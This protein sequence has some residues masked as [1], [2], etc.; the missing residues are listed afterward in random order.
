VNFRDA[1]SHGRDCTLTSTFPA[2][3]GR[4]STTHLRHRRELF[5]KHGVRLPG[6]LRCGDA[7]ES[8][9]H[10]CPRHRRS[11]ERA[12]VYTD[13]PKWLDA[14]GISLDYQV[15]LIHAAVFFPASGHRLNSY[16]V[17]GHAIADIKMNVQPAPVQPPP[18]RVN[19][20]P[21]SQYPLSHVQQPLQSHG[22]PV[23]HHAPQ[24]SIQHAVQPT[25]QHV[26]PPAQSAP[27][28]DP[29]ILSMGKRTSVAPSSNQL[30]AAPPQEA[31]ATPIKPA[32]VAGPAPAPKEASQFAAHVRGFNVRK[33]SAATLEGPFSSLD[34]AD[35]EEADSET[36][37]AK[38]NVRRASITKTR[39][40]KPMD[41]PS[42]QKLDDGGKKT[43]R[44][45][46]SRKKE[47][48][49]Q[50]RK[51]GGDLHLSPDVVRKGYVPSTFYIVLRAQLTRNDASNKH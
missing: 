40:G 1:R 9:E 39:N 47:L 26:Q 29:A 18:P 27:F 22:L 31:P 42:P 33:P 28:V 35:A 49:A 17:E 21:Y 32:S 50:E 46:K 43:R 12:N 36:K 13:A 3:G 23:Q 44:G 41:D 38:P 4:Q 11:C 48:A 7:A 19:P 37:T 5:R 2:S 25:R 6:Y 15:M 51:N 24:R 10:G 14:L 45:G 8:T 20:S 16:H 34:I 30:V